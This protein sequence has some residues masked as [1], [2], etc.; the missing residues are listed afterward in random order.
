MK[1][2]YFIVAKLMVQYIDDLI[3]ILTGD[4][5][6]VCRRSCCLSL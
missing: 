5:C 4:D 2:R 1:I 6:R 3:L